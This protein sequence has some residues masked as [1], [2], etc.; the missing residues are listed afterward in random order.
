MVVIIA[1]SD[2]M[3]V[4]MFCLLTKECEIYLWLLGMDS[5][6]STLSGR[7][8]CLSFNWLTFLLKCITNLLEI[9][10]VSLLLLNSCLTLIAMCLWIRQNN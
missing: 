7:I 9:S 2:E 6:G 1:I 8:A 3:W 4:L 5:I 10:F